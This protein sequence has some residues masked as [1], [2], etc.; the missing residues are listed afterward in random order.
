VKYDP[1]IHHRHSIRLKGY[2]YSSA[3]AYFV[4]AVL[5]HRMHLFGRV[6]ENGM[7]LSEAG[8]IAHRCWEEIP[9]HFPHTALDEFV[10]MPDHLHG[11]V[12]ILGEDDY[13][14]SYEDGSGGVQLNAPKELNAPSADIS[15][16]KAPVLGSSIM[17]IHK[18][19]SPQSTRKD[20]YFSIISPRKKTLSV[21]IRTYKAAVTT[22]CRENGIHEFQWQRNYYERIIR[23]ERGMA[24]VRRYILNN[25]AKW[26]REREN[27]HAM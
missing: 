20:N 6:C 26:L 9:L 1:A 22:I 7:Q 12:V 24:A 5:Q 21:V 19:S 8:K 27:Q 15:K 17:K 16:S 13:G 3:G 23:D 11:I 4:T 18:S 10:I 25:P 14:E 2:D